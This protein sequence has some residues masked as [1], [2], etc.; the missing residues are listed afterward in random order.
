VVVCNSSSGRRSVRVDVDVGGEVS[1]LVV[2]VQVSVDVGGSGEVVFVSSVVGGRCAST[3]AGGL[4]DVHGRVDGQPLVRI[5]LS[6][7]WVPCG[8]SSTVGCG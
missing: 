6:A 3:S 4:F 8:C 7:Q 1:S 5:D 2:G